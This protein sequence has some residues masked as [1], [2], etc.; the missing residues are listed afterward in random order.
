MRNLFVNEVPENLRP[1]ERL[2]SVGVHAL[3]DQELLAILLRTGTRDKNVLVVALDLLTQ[4]EDLASL[5]TASLEEFQ[6]V[7]GIGQAKA[8]ELMAAIEFGRRVSEASL[9]RSTRIDSTMTAGSYLIRMM[10]HL[11][12]EHLY[13]FFLNTKNYII[14]HKVIFIGTVNA[15]VAH[16][17]EIFKEAVKYPTAR[18]IIGHNHPSGD[19]TPSAADITFT[20]RLIA[21]GDMMG[22]DILDHIIV[23]GEEYVSLQET[24]KLF[25]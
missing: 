10:R 25:E 3:S 5:R 22:I 23:A 16:P 9:P 21:C 12:Q 13:A 8:I 17:R 1:R 4:M 20:R 14:K 15:S 18:I 6:L 19:P 7:D 2:L 11:Q 24:T